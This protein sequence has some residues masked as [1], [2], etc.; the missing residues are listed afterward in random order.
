MPTGMMQTGS[1][2]WKHRLKRWFWP[3][4]EIKRLEEEEFRLLALNRFMFLSMKDLQR[5]LNVP[6]VFDNSHIPF[7]GMEVVYKMNAQE[8]FPGEDLV[9]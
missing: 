1:Y 4:S 2:T 5:L 9:H 3:W 8:A 7:M 6:S